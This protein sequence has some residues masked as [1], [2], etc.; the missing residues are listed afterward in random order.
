[1]MPP[2][3]SDAP[4]LA[5]LAARFAA[6]PKRHPGLVWDDVLARLR[7]NAAAR[8]TLAA[9]DASGG[10]PDVI[11]RDETTGAYLFVDCSVQSPTGRRSCCF[12]RAALASRKAN[13]PAHSAEELAEAMGVELLDEV[14]YRHLQTLG[15]FDTTTSSWLRTPDRIRALGGALFGDRRFDT[16]FVYHNG[17]ESYYA[18]RGFRGVLRV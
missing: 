3:D 1:M 2:A 5:T 17:A 8:R 15:A 14:L 9:M 18:A 12:D 11:G 6:H 10:E 13:K 4:L 16:V 7:D